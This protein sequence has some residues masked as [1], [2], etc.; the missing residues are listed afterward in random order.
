GYTGS[1]TNMATTGAYQ[2]TNAGGYDV[3]LTA[4]TAAGAMVWSTFYGTT[5]DEYGWSVHYNGSDL[6]ISGTSNFLGTYDFLLAKFTL[7]GVLTYDW[8]I[9]AAGDE[10]SYQLERDA[11]G[12]IYMSGYTSSFSGVANVGQTT[13]GGGIADGY[14]VKCD[15]ASGTVIWATYLGGNSTDALTTV[16]CDAAGNIYACGYSVSGNNIGTV[17]TSQPMLAGGYDGILTKFSSAGSQIWGT[18]LGDGAEEY[19]LGADADASGN[20]YITG[21]AQSGGL[22]T[23]GAYQSAPNGFD[24][25]LVAKYNTS[26]IKQW[27]TYMGGSFDDDGQGL[28]LDNSNNLYIVGWTR[29][30]TNIATTGSYDVS[31]DGNKEGFVSKFTITGAMVWSSYYGGFGDDQMNMCSPDNLGNVFVAGYSGSTNTI[32]FNTTIQSSNSGTDDAVIAKFSDCVSLSQPGIISGNNPVCAGSTQTY[33]IAAV[34]GAISYTWTFPTG[35][36]GTSTTTSIT[37]TAGTTGGSISVVANN[38]CGSSA[39]QTQTVTVNPIPTASISAGGPTT[40][41]QGSNVALNAVTGTGYSYQWYNGSNPISG[42]TSAT[43]SAT[44]TGTYSVQVTASGCSATSSTI[45]VTVNPSPVTPTATSNSPM[46][47]GAALNLYGTTSTTGVTY[48]WTG[49]NNFP[50]TQNPV[51]ATA[52]ISDAGTYTLT[53]VDGNNCSSSATVTVSVASGAPA[54]PSAISGPATIC[55]GTTNTYSVTN[56]VNAAS[57]TWT[58]PTGWSGTSA[59]N[60]ISAVAGTAGG[61]ISVVA[62]NGCGTSAASTLNVTVNPLPTPTIVQAGSSLTTTTTYNT[63]QWYDGSGQIPGAT[64]QSYTPAVSGNYYVVVTDGN[65]CSGQSTALTFNTGVQNVGNEG[66][67]TLF[68]N[69]NNG[70]FAI[71]GAF[72]ANDGKV[73]VEVIDIAG[74]IVHKEQVMIT[75]NTIT[76]SISL[77]A[78]LAPGV[79]TL[80]LHSDAQNSVIPFVKR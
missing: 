20:I 23:T 39:P 44:A 55:A 42:A 50:N 25:V 52:S 14:L 63:Y 48:N 24:D 66:S 13:Y 32:A 65:G 30:A 38:S 53:V 6:V 29:S 59:T 10:V 34:T 9:G 17:G 61:T 31:Y 15:N 41:C 80:K 1:L 58:L 67:F 5:A 3:I 74:R 12:N 78:S 56:D 43:Y 77:N 7:G 46:C 16:D 36:T 47:A 18:Y 26:G 64:S 70:S 76:T 57:Y 72:V 35:W 68:P 37:V 62:V 54:T 40:F 79:Y 2:T 45:S 60:S 28:A 75:K 33:T 69:P 4:T 19:V 27:F 21:S 11:S 51:I 49:P 22:A 73:N 8:A 71:N